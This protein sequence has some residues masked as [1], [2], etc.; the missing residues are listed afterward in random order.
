MRVLHVD[1]GREMRGG[2]WQVLRLV[3]GLGPDSVLLTPPGGPLLQAAE[4]RGLDARPLNMMS[5][6]ALSRRADLTHAHDARSHA[7]TAALGGSRLVVSRR[8]AF[9]VARSV[10]SRWKYRRPDHYLAVSE[11]VKRTLVE[12]EVPAERV[13]VVYDG[14]ELPD[15]VAAPNRIVAL[16][17][18]DPLKGRSLMEKA[19]SLA[20]VEVHYSADLGADLPTA[21]VFVYITHSE[22]LG[23]AALMAMAH[24]VPV[25]ASQI[26]GLPEIVIHEQTGILTRNDP[27]AIAA[28]IRKALDMRERLSATARRCVEERFST[29]HMIDNTL[30]AYRKVLA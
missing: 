13:S 21:S 23:S 30:L 4:E 5:L 10:L 9:A 8:V 29:R 20:G 7:W 18:S 25:V 28:A 6:S 1:S 11:H 14:V 3:Q 2:Q 24:G 19:A 17:S 27:Q 16:A 12:A 22:G 15:T 26:G